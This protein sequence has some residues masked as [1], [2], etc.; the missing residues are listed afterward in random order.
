MSDSVYVPLPGDIGLTQISGD[1]GR[2]IRFGQW[3]DGDGFA[4]YEHAFVYTGAGH[5]VEAEPGGAL[6]SL[7]ERYDAS[8]IAWLR[9][10]DPYRVNVC[11]AAKLYVG[12]PYSFADYAAIAAHR[13][14]LPVPGLRG[15]IESTGHMICSQLADRAAM[16]GGWHLFSDD[17]WPGYVDPGALW[18]LYAR[19][20]S[21]AAP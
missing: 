2:A 19:Q 18:R 13:A 9:C 5:I 1:V 17:R 11:K 20:V 3:L 8:R 15:Y 16:D 7:L 12:V 10:P 4:D 21:G 14:R 6:D